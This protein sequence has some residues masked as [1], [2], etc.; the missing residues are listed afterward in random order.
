MGRK[1]N[2]MNFEL[3]ML[4]YSGLGLDMFYSKKKYSPIENKESSRHKNPE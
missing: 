4:F 1:I 2:F 3:L